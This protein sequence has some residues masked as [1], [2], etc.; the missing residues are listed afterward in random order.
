VPNVV[1]W[2]QR[3]KLLRGEFEYERTGVMDETHL[4]FFTFSNADRCL[5]AQATQI[6]CVEK[7]ADGSVP[8]WLLRRYLFPRWLSANLDR[9]GVRLWPNLFASQVLVKGRK[10]RTRD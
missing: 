8:L 7:R 5:L 3:V 9:V 6:D 2:R 4:R 10:R 1:N